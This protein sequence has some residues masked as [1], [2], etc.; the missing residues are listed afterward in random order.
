MAG[1]KK[2]TK[3]TRTRIR[4]MAMRAMRERDLNPAQVRRLVNDA[5]DGA[6][7]QV[8]REIPAARRRQISEAFHGLRDAFQSAASA[9]INT[10]KSAKRRGKDLATHALPAA[11][12]KVAAANEEFLEAVSA[13]AKKTSSEFGKELESLVRRSRKAGR[14][15]AKST[16]KAGKIAADNSVPLAR[17]AGRAGWSL[18]RKAVEQIA[19]AASGLM[20]GIGQLV[21]PK[22]PSPAMATKPTR[23]KKRRGKSRAKKSKRASGKKPGSKK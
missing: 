7:K 18:A 4:E 11:R 15:I 9:G 16:S 12:Q 22:H 13:F 1:R 10:G 5:L 3:N 8:K 23:R 20:E 19:L 17:D 21:A 6:A 2:A 14:S